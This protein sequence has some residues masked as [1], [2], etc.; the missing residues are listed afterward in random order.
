[1]FTVHL[2]TLYTLTSFNHYLI[3]FV[4]SYVST[5][6]DNPQ[7]WESSYTKGVTKIY[8]RLGSRYSMINSESKNKNYPV[9]HSNI[10]PFQ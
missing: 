10:P 6:I 2:A 9:H 7:T 4:L 3:S 1:M 8:Q 5:T